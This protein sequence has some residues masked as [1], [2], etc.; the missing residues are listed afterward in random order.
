MR[1]GD[2]IP[3]RLESDSRL[4]LSALS[5]DI[6]VLL[7]SEDEETLT[8][9]LVRLHVAGA[10]GSDADELDTA[11]SRVIVGRRTSLWE[12]GARLV[13]TVVV[14]LAVIAAGLLAA[15]FAGQAFP[16]FVPVSWLTW[17]PSPRIF[18]AVI[19]LVVVAAVLGYAAVWLRS[20]DRVRRARLACR[21]A[22]VHELD[23]WPGILLD[24]PF[25]SLGRRWSYPGWSFVI[26][27]VVLGAAPLSVSGI[28]N[29]LL[30]VAIV[31]I[32]LGAWLV[33]HSWPFRRAQDLA[34]RTLFLGRSD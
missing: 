20:T 2:V 30:V 16:R 31:W 32:V 7:R 26:A 3:E 17:P 21:L 15:S 27:G 13:I 8:E 28:S 9:R 22:A 23:S 12:V 33:W 1:R 4:I 34:E 11:V 6:R 24:A 14:V 18:R 5:P 25:L 10:T 29:W 19:L